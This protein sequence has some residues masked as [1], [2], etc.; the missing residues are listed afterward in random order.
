MGRAEGKKWKEKNDVIIFFNL[1]LISKTKLTL[2]SN[3]GMAVHACNASTEEA[4]TEGSQAQGQPRLQHSAFQTSQ[5]VEQP[6][7]DPTFK[8]RMN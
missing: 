3:L 5:R 6:H 4:E 2:N 7:G 1:E 8:E